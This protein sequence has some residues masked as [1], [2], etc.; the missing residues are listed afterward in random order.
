MNSSAASRRVI[1]R[2]SHSPRTVAMVIVVVIVTVGLAYLGIEI[3]LSALGTRALLASPEAAATWVTTLPDQQPAGA[4]I[5]AGVLLAMIGLLLIALALSP[6][7]LPKHE[8]VAD[9]SVVLVDNG[10]LASALAQHLSDHIG[11][12]RDRITVGV[13]RRVVDVT[14]APDAGVAVPDARIR[15]LVAT[16]VDSYR[17]TRP[18]KTRVR[19]SKQREGVPS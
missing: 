13:S 14:V 12:A 3:V 18:V 4:I 10:V 1:R 9:G 2:E 6:G 19:A 17:L 5:A 8:M 11:V 7:R 16:E 15:D